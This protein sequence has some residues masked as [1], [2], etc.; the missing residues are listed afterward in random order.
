MQ[1]SMWPVI[2]SPGNDVMRY[3]VSRGHVATLSRIYVG[4]VKQ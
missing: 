4:S 2:L 3:D 1:N